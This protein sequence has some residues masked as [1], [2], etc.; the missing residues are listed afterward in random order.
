MDKKI[1]K[2]TTEIK[3]GKLTA[4]ASTEDRDRSGDIIKVADWDFSHFNNNPVLQA[5]HDYKP[6]FTIGRAKNLRIEGKRVLFEPEFHEITPLA[7]QIKEMYEQGFLKA[8]SV[9]FIPA[10][11]HDR[12]SHELLEVSA[13]AVP[14][15][16]SALM[17]SMENLETK[18]CGEIV[19]K[20]EEWMKKDTDEVLELEVK[21]VG[22]TVEKK[23]EEKAVTTITTSET[24][25]H[26]HIATVDEETGN[27]T[28]DEVNDHVHSISEFILAK[29]SG[30]THTIDVGEGDMDEVG[31]NDAEKKPKKSFERWNKSLP[32]IFNKEFDIESVQANR[33][34]TV[35]VLSKFLDVEV[36]N[37]FLNN[38]EVPSPLLGTYLAAFKY[39]LSDYDLIDTRNFRYD[40]AEYPPSY[41]VVQLNSQKSDDFLIQGTRF[42][43]VKGVNE[44]IVEFNPGWGGMEISII[45]SDSKKEFNKEILEKIHKWVEENNF[46]KGE[47]FA[48]S[49]E[50]ITKGENKWDDVFLKGKQKEVIQNSV[51]IL[52]KEG[53]SLSRGLLFIGPPGTGKTKTGKIILDN[54]DSTFIWISSKD[55]DRVG[56]VG[57]I[58]LAFRLA[59]SLGKSVLFMED[60]DSWLYR[61][62]T[63][64]LKTE[65]D[66][67]QEN[68]NLITILTSNHPEALPDAL[69]DRPGRF[70]EIINFDLPDKKARKEMLEKWVGEIKEI[71]DIIEKTEGFSGAHMKELVEYAKIIAEDKEVE[72]KDV[73]LESLQKLLDQKELIQ[74]IK[75][76]RKMTKSFNMV[77][78]KEGRILSKKNRSVIHDAKEALEKVLEIQEKPKEEEIKEY[79]KEE[80][81]E[82][83]EVKDIKKSASESDTALIKA[84]QSIVSVGNQTLRKNKKK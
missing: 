72:I 63:D 67:M 2:A 16:Q 78:L 81:Q 9:G 79:S 64:L 69:L 10:D 14:A 7:K 57:A 45:T 41:G 30:H 6:Q 25:D 74:D 84:L 49:G 83:I 55:M 56:P 80:V 3:A 32:E 77:E 62:A 5:G 44:L 39:V 27:G 46:L 12:K 54:V 15:N 61:G 22:E 36:K 58:K 11:G 65:M 40:G 13:V 51:K 48:L 29:A 68:K 50:F 8:W 37:V 4:I 35:D 70:H 42:Y 33:T 24:N 59:R 18:D 71:D 28:T 52:E 43:K 75:K 17:K 73:L 26:T 38:F 82:L 66:G 20:I 76:R 21:E 31:E 1:L 60:I 23:K 47:K 34:F 19:S 53:D